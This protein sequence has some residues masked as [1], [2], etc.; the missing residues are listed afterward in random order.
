[1]QVKLHSH[2]LQVLLCCQ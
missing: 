1:M 2:R